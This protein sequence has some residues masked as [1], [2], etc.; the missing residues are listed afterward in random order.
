MSA[1]TT[2]ENSQLSSV[3]GPVKSWRFGRSL[4]IDPIGL[5]STCSFNCVYC[6]L[7]TIQN[8]TSQRQIF[9][10]TTQIIQDLQAIGDVEIDVVT[11]SGSGE[12]TLALNL[13]EILTAVKKITQ[14]PAV[15]LTNSSLLSDRTVRNALALA[16]Y[17]AVKLDA[18]ESNQLQRVSRPVATINLADILGGITQFRREYPGYLAIQTMVLSP[19]TPEIASNYIQIVKNINPDEIQLN[20]PSRPRVLVRQL[21]ARG[22][23]VMTFHGDNLQQLHCISADLLASLA[24]QIYNSTKITV[25]CA[26]TASLY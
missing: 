4:G 10:P 6:Q 13:L 18:M 26:P 17:V 1:T 5:V 8:H 9:I 22:N 24:A 7:G 20:I 15:V 19:W 16:D 2:T 23:E 21:D 3:Y 12:P 14:K 25:R 11:L